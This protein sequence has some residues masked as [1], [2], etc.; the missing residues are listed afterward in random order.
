M[1]KKLLFVF[2]FTLTGLVGNAQNNVIDKL[3]DHPL[4]TKIIKGDTFLQ[5]DLTEYL[6]YTQQTNNDTNINLLSDYFMRPHPSVF[7]IQKYFNQ[8]ASEF[9]LPV[10]LLM[11]IGQIENNW[12]QTGPTID[13]GWGI[14]HLVKNNYCNTLGDASKILGVSEQVLKDDAFQNIRGA[15]ALIVKYAGKNKKK[16]KKIEDWFH[17]VAKFS[18]LINEEL[19]NIQAL[20]YYETLKNGIISR[21][22]W[23]ETIC[24]LPQSSI[25]LEELSKNQKKKSKLAIKSTDYGP[26][27]SNLAPS[28]NYASS[29]THTIDTWVMHYVGTGTYSGAISWFLNCASGVSAHFV[30]RSSDGQITQCVA[31]ANTAWHCG[32]S[33]YPYNNPR[34]IGIEHE[35][36]AANPGLWNSIPMLQASATMACYFKNVYGFPSTQNTSPGICGHSSMPGT[37]TACPGALPWLTWFT[38]FNSACSVTPPSNDGCPGAQLTVNS[39]CN[40]VAG[41]TIGATSSGFSSCSGDMNDDDVF[42]YFNTGTSTS[43]TIKVLGS[44]NF[45]AAFQVLAGSCGSSMSQLPNGCVDNTS[46]GLETHTYTGLNTNTTYYIRIGSFGLGS[47]NQGDFQL[48]VYDSVNTQQCII[49]SFNPYSKTHGSESFSTT[50]GIDNII[51]NTQANCAFSITGIS[52]WLTVT[53]MNGTANISGQFFLNYTLQANTT[54]LA[55]ICTFYVNGIPYTIIQN[56]CSNAYNPTIKNVSV[57]GTTYNLEIAG[58][59]TI[60]WSISNNCNWVHLSQ[61]NGNGADTIIVTVD[62]SELCTSRICTFLFNNCNATHTITQS[63]NIIP[64]APGITQ[65][66]N[67]LFSNYSYGNQWYNEFGLIQGATNQTYLV[68]SNGSF[69]DIVTINGCSSDP[70]NTIQFG[71]SI[72][73]NQNTIKVIKIYP[74]PAF[75]KFIIE[76]SGNKDNFNFEIL[77]SIGQIVYKGNVIENAIV[78]TTKL[79]PGVYF[80]KL[81]DGKIIEFR[82]IIKE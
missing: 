34:S 72:E 79:A 41:T 12:T 78:Q 50:P 60:N 43:V 31:V 81:T 4:T 38:F 37:S 68:T 55:R 67:T 33:A 25:N 57:S 30:I 9:D 75:E 19:R 14:M 47:S 17:A 64:Q 61:N 15:A 3:L 46:S 74:S 5:K 18:G 54:A 1:I 45:D 16:F 35:A 65:N 69:Y 11:V 71:S 29:R 32:A 6:N 82:K 49:T 73:I 36:T 58:D 52:S 63:G 39:T 23:D 53:P 21:T 77:N 44:G 40:Y 62:S 76:I 13:Q 27:L 66:G 20:T 26:A 70:S 2:I 22:V 7:T 8:V 80:I 48:C 56:G 10:S 28:C 59:V 42:Y 51:V 24:I